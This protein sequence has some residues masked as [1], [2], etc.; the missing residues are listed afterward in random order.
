[1]RRLSQHGMT[2]LEIM[3]AMTILSVLAIFTIP[4]MKGPHA[5]NKLRAGSREI[6]SLMRMARSTAVLNEVEVIL[7]LDEEENRYRL[8]LDNVARKRRLAE[9]KAV[10]RSE[11]ANW[12]DLPKNISFV[13]VVSLDDEKDRDGVTKILFY[14]DGSASGSTIVLKNEADKKMTVTLNRATALPEVIKGELEEPVESGA[15]S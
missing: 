15:S 8:N 9:R 2:F 12:R 4:N 6:V 11:I 14:P 10:E 1:M 7:E 13:S 3:I 5:F